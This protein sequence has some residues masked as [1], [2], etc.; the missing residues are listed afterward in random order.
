MTPS[1]TIRNLSWTFGLLI[2]GMWV[3][4][5][6][7]GNLGGTSVLGNVRDLHPHVYGIALLCAIGAVIVTAV[8]GAV[9]AYRTFSIASALRVGIWSGMIS[10]AIAAVACMGITVLFHDAMMTDPSNIHEFARSALRPPTQ[11]E[12]SAFLYWDAVGGAFNHLWIGPLLGI[13]IGGPGAV[14]GRLGS[15]GRSQE[16]S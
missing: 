13:M 14:L 16:A 10:G 5:V 15:R 7:L 12:L 2:G 4:E 9:A 6:L 1:R 3:G 11:A 8:G